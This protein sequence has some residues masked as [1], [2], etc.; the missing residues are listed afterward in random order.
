MFDTLKNIN[1][2]F[3]FGRS[4]Y[5]ITWIQTYDKFFR[6]ESGFNNIVNKFCKENNFEH[7]KIDAI[8]Q[9]DLTQFINNG[10]HF[11]CCVDFVPIDN[12]LL[13]ND[14]TIKHID[15]IKA[16]SQFQECSYYTGFVGSITDFREVDNFTQLGL[17]YT[18]ILPDR[19]PNELWTKGGIL[20]VP[21]SR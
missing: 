16:Y 21:P 10:T 13:E 12:R 11:N 18:G 14:N 4:R 2:Y 1:E 9:P 19:G 20:Y 5:G 8:K 17:Y 7:F 15:I 6:L 3:I